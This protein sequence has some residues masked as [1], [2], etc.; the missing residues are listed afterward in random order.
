MLIEAAA[1]LT[2]A[3]AETHSSEMQA[4][5]LPSTVDQPENAGSVECPMGNLAADAVRFAAGSD[6]AIVNGGDLNGGLEQ[7][8]VLWE[9][10]LAVFNEDRPLAVAEISPRQLYAML[11]NA[12][13][14]IV[15]DLQM[16]AINH[17][18]SQFDGFAH[19]SG[20]SFRY[21]ASA[22]S[23]ARVISVTLENGT[24]LLPEDDQTVLT[25]AASRYMLSG[26]YGYLQPDSVTLMEDSLSE[27]LAALISSGAA[28]VSSGRIRA[29]GVYE[30]GIPGGIPVWVIS[31]FGLFCIAVLFGVRSR[32]SK[33][34]ETYY[35][36]FF[37]KD[38]K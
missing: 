35:K 7:G 30:Q 32:L 8:V 1:V 24:E 16:E 19:V 2:A 31:I 22:P 12:V 29:I 17:D 5:R 3:A 37:K 18:A 23:G 6:I 14:G 20:F 36:G 9:D 4:G 10:V 25:L 11:E 38:W 21:D 28:A 34:T 33:Q 13:S 15:V 26:G 27:A